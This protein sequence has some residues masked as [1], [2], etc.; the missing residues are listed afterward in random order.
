MDACIHGEAAA[1]K[2]NF[3]IVDSAARPPK[4]MSARLSSNCP[5]TAFTVIATI[6]HFVGIAIVRVRCDGHSISIKPSKNPP[7]TIC[8]P[9]AN[10]VT[11]GMVIRIISLGT[12]APKDICSHL[13]IA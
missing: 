6:N 13:R 4:A 12:N 7:N 11:D 3:G 5:A 8:A 9:I 10:V 1:S 2:K